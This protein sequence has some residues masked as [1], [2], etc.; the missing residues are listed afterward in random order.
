MN[1]KDIQ[2]A[3]EDVFSTKEEAEAWLSKPH[4]FLQNKTPMEVATTEEGFAQVSNLLS[5]IKFGGVV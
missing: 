1:L 3:A 2:K 5:S 4:P